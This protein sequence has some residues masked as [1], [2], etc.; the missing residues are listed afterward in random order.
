MRVTFLAA[1]LALSGYT[2]AADLMKRTAP[3]PE[4]LPVEQAFELQ[5]VESKDGKLAVSWRVTPEHYLFKVRLHFASQ[6][7]GLKLGAIKLPKGKAY[8]DELLG[9][10]EIYD[11]DLRVSIPA[12][13]AGTL[14]VTY[15]GCAKKGLC[16]PPQTRELKVSIAPAKKA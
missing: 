13:G 7:P 6:S 5:P 3:A 16:Y 12:T 4:F 8:K 14:K 2:Q 1:L 10:T 9:D 11:S 15:Q